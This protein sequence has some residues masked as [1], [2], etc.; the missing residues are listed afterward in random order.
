MVSIFGRAVNILCGPSFM[1]LRLIRFVL[2]GGVNTVLGYILYATFIFIGLNY[3]LA[4]FLALAI[5][6]IFGFFAQRTFVFK[7]HNRWLFL[8]FVL[9]WAAMYFIN[10]VAIGLLIRSGFDAYISGAIIVAP[11]AIISYFLQKFY[12]FR[13]FRGATFYSKA[14]KK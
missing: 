4:N 5:S 8:R 9:A 2:V 14:K 6:V 11:G 13:V 1:R 3:N 10:M 7:N 12:V